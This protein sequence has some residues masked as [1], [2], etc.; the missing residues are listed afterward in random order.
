MKVEFREEPGQ[1][2]PEVVITASRKTPELEELMDRLSG[3]SLGPIPVF[4]EGQAVLLEPSSILRFFTDG[5]GVS[6]QTGDGVFSV[7]R[8]LYELEET[9]DPHTF[10]RVSNS[11]IVNLKR[12][13]AIDLS[14]VGTIRM[15][16]GD[17]VY[18]YVSR[19]Y[20]KKIKSAVGL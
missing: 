1:L 12:V 18:A 5:K 11:E 20:M 7:R 19:R 16:L 6:A 13:T 17:G 4:R 3:L 15:T 14:L 8:R 2:E 9:L 10:V